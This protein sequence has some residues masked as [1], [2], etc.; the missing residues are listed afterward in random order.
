MPNTTNFTLPYPQ[1]S[2]TVDVPRD[3]SA[4]A[5]S[6]DTA[7]LQTVRVYASTTARDTAIT[8][9]TAGMIVYINSNDSSEGLYLYAGSTGGWMKGPGWNAPWGVVSYVQ[10]TTSQGSITTRVA[11]TSMT[12]GS[13]TYLANRVLRISLQT[14]KISTDTAGDRVEVFLMNGATTLSSCTANITAA[15][16]GSSTNLVYYDTTTAGARTYS[17]EISRSAGTGTASTNASSTNP[18]Q[19]IVEDIGPSGAPA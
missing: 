17:L 6:V 16:R 8:S 2:D 7:L 1:A 12:T 19:L 9:P 18:F 15:S 4:L 13:I 5:S 14:P 11:A 3:I 10:T